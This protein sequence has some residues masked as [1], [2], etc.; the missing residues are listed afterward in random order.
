MYFN[1][2]YIDQSM[3]ERRRGN[4][5]MYYI[6]IDDPQHSA[7]IAK[8]STP[9]PQFHRADQDRIRA[10]FHRRLSGAA[11]QRQDVPD[12]HL[13]RGDVHGPAG[14]G[15]HHGDVG[16]RTR[17]R[18]GHPEDA[19]LHPGHHSGHDSGRS[20]RDLDRRRRHRLPHFH[21]LM[22]KGVAK[23]PF[24]GYLPSLRLR[25]PVALACVLT[26]AAIGL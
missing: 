19:G 1:K 26:A 16:A 22:R 5:I 8:P 21:L 15:Q 4:V 12:R 9:V 3:P 23:S 18:S 2:E 11:R 17:A 24:G 6:L 10:G 13:R 25:D 7:R 14:F 20:L